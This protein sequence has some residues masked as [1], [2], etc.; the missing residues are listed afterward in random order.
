MPG[1]YIVLVETIFCDNERDATV[2]QDFF[3]RWYIS[4]RALASVSVPVD[5][6]VKYILYLSDDKL[7]EKVLVQAFLASLNPEVARRF[8]VVPYEHPTD[9]YGSKGVV[10]PDSLKNPNKTA[11]RRDW[12]FEAALTRISVEG[13]DRVIRA[14]LDDDD[15]WLP[16]QLHEIV[17]A[18]EGVFEPG[19]I[20][21]VGLRN[22]LVA[23]H[24]ASKVDV[25]ELTHHMN[26]NKFYLSEI[27][28]FSRQRVLSPWSIPED[29]NEANVARMG[30][31]G[32]SL[33]SVGENNP[34]WIYNRWGGNL[35]L[36]DKSKYYIQNMSTFG[37][38]NAYE[39]IDS[40]VSRLSSGVSYE[41][42][43][44]ESSNDAGSEV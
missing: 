10:H 38:D 42:A 30:R 6:T 39:L 16:W 27:G 15:F 12:L 28:L 18:A 3:Q 9:G 24:D 33:T 35:S 31:A 44:I 5:C 19:K 7:Q 40:A 2:R 8:V 20:L 41:G 43:S 29:F 23:Y 34:G 14:T 22:A 26:G 32:V 1:K 13:Y 21:G 25:V 11:P 4:L 37:F 17:Q 36:H